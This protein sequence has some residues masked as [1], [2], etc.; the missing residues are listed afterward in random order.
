MNMMSPDDASGVWLAS[1]VLGLLEE[2]YGP[3]RIPSVRVLAR[4]IRDA[5]GGASIS[6]GQVHNILNG[7][8]TNITDRTRE[9]LARFLG[10]HPSRLVPPPRPASGGQPGPPLAETLAMRLSCLRPEEL[11]AIEQAIALVRT[12]RDDERE[13]N[14]RASTP[15]DA[16]EEA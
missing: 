5:N 3:G 7:G 4:Q 6:H 14:E 10:V 16:S 2:R 9:I 8:A 12:Q 13:P 1:A 15:I 11:A